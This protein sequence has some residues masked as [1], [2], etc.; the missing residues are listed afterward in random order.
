MS[1]EQPAWEAVRSLTDRNRILYWRYGT[2]WRW[3]GAVT[4]LGSR[5][6]AT[7]Y[8]PGH[9]GSRA[10]RLGLHDNRRAVEQAVETY[11][12]EEVQ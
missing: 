6:L 4:P 11:A 7:G 9:P 1:T 3:F 2:T 12:A 5:W 8:S 10:I